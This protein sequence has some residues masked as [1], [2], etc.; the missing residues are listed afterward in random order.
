MKTRTNQPIELANTQ[1]IEHLSDSFLNELKAGDIITKQ[2]GEQKH[3]YV[4]SYKEEKHGICLTYVDCGYMETI[5]YDYT[6]GH[7]VFNSKDVIEVPTQSGTKLYK[8]TLGFDDVGEGTATMFIDVI[9]LRPAQFSNEG[10]LE[11][12]RKQIISINS[13][14]NSGKALYLFKSG[15]DWCLKQQDDYYDDLIYATL[16]AFINDVVTPL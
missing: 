5:S 3:T 8:H 10:D 2:T 14:V 6:N 13:S 11:D 1:D 16:G 4:V 7:W 12:Y 15:D 9:M